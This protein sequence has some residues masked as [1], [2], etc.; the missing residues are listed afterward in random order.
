[1]LN[2]PVKCLGIHFENDEARRA[3]FLEELRKKLQGPD[4][5]RFSGFP[6]ATDEAILALSDP[7]YYTAC[8][9]PWLA[10][11]LN[12]WEQNHNNYHREP[13]AT[14]VTEGKNDPIYNAHS[15]HTKV[16]HKAIMRY[17]L[18]YTEP[19]NVVFDGFCG[20]GMT[21]VAAQL[22]GDQKTIESLGYRVQPD[23]TIEAQDEN[24]KS[25]WQ[26]FSKLGARRAILNDLS[27]AATF[28]AYNYNT[29]V[30]AF[31]LE[32]EAHRILQAVETECGWMYQ[33][34][35]FSTKNIKEH[36]NDIKKIILGEMA[37]PIWIILGRINYTVWSDIFI[38][39]ECA[40]DVIFWEAA[41]NREAGKPQFPCP[42]CDATL[43]KRTLERA[44][45]TRFDTAISETVRQA[46]QV[47]VLINYSVG[48][49]RYEKTP[50]EF[51]LALLEKIE[52]TEVPYWFPTVALPKG[53]KMAEPLHLG[54]THVHH[55]YSKRALL[56]LQCG[57][58]NVS[59][60][61]ENIK[62]YMLF[63]IQQAVLG[64]AKI[65]RYVPNH[66]SQV[67]QYLSGT[68]YISSQIVDVSLEYIIAGKIR[69]LTQLLGTYHKVNEAL[70][71]CQ[72]FSDFKMEDAVIDYIFL[73]PPFGSN[74]MY[75]ELN[76]LWESWLQVFT[77]NQQEAIVNKTQ[78]KKLSDYRALIVNCFK[79]AFRILKPGHWMTVEFSNTRAGVWNILQ[80]TLQ[81]A[82]FI[83]ANVSALD[84]KQGSFNAVTNTIS[85]KQ[86]LIISAYKPNS[87]LEE[88]FEKAAGSEA[89]VWEFVRNHL[90]YL[91]ITKIKNGELEW[92]SEREPRILYDR[93]VAYFIGHGYSVPLSSQQ[94]QAGLREHF[95]ER[96]GMIFRLE[97]IENY[98]QK[99]KKTKNS[100]QLALLISDER[101]AID[102][103]NNFL[104]KQPST[105]QDIHPKL[106]KLLGAGWK[107]HE[108]MVELDTLLEFNF[109]KYEGK[110][111]VP[112]QIHH[113][114]SHQFKACRN[115]EKDNTI[116]QQYAT[117]RWYI[118]EQYKAQD[119]EKIREAHLLHEFKQY[120]QS[121]KKRLKAFRLE[122]MRTGFKNAW[123]QQDY[124]TIIEMSHK[125]PEAALY[126]DE[127]LLQLYDLAM[128]RLEQ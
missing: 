99:R 25:G 47:P 68:L 60:L 106:I 46:K 37:C 61:N 85:V 16:P 70:V 1:M 74:L 98:E 23:G 93:T 50:D 73:D 8:P 48:K 128:V 36:T 94:F 110:G 10:D 19:G 22:C 43:T 3:Y 40:N 27:P 123:A 32:Q 117:E 6:H 9:N 53:D 45:I 119:L 67:N 71:A 54:I 121:Q 4:F 118:P 2:L 64:M 52:K 127:K 58:H 109:L 86:D 124:K 102:W 44:W 14:D 89:G 11:F 38:C 57:Y 103:L 108:L 76:F 33:T 12:E 18:H 55:F 41:V 39:P 56:T 90:N 49:T 62:H 114:L 34:L 77:N 20:T 63:V 100:P 107:K 91:P 84:K 125:I 96:D 13:F 75:S 126:E 97:Q 113:Y 82:G 79:E 69:R 51:D 115:L 122:V 78:N 111:A 31:T 120:R 81:E 87:G 30:D 29:P 7:P 72:N 28:I 15:Y 59:S 88:R 66:Y 42:H 112:S 83:I 24:G 95:K 5:K 101:S 92:I 35:H 26:P 80:T 21:G 65:A 105:R 17:I 116:L 104:K